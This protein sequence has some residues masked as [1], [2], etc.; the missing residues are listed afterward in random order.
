MIKINSFEWSQNNFA[1]ILERFSITRKKFLRISVFIFQVRER[2]REREGRAEKWKK[3]KARR[4]ERKGRERPEHSV[5]TQEI[6]TILCLHF[7][8]G[9][10]LLGM[11]DSHRNVSSARPRGRSSTRTISPAVSFADRQM[12]A[13]A[14]AA[15]DRAATAAD[16]QEDA[17]SGDAPPQDDHSP[18]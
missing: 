15:L 4:N 13:Q 5:T 8:V 10:G 7:P 6:L 18:P 14:R 1:R 11:S 16:R 2:K 9:R 3:D 12:D 17:L